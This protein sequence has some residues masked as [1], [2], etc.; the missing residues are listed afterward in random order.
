[1]MNVF[2]RREKILAANEDKTKEEIKGFMEPY[3]NKLDKRKEMWNKAAEKYQS[4]H[5][6]ILENYYQ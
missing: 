1:M 6:F 2:R 3:M 5:D 4:Y